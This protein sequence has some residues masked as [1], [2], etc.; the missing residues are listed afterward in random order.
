MIKIDNKTYYR[1]KKKLFS[2]FVYVKYDL[3]K[4]RM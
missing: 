3:S 2:I 4:L 1:L